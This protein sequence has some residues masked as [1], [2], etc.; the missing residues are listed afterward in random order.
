MSSGSG[1]NGVVLGASTTIAGVA[2][3]PNTGGQDWVLMTAIAITTAGVVLLAFR[4]YAAFIEH[5]D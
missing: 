1:D 5:R 3:L 4:A 2:I